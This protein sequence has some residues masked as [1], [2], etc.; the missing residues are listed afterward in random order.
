MK[1][2]QKVTT[3]ILALTVFTGTVN[4]KMPTNIDI[5][6][7]QSVTMTLILESLE[8]HSLAIEAQDFQKD[9]K[10]LLAQKPSTPTTR[11]FAADRTMRSAQSVSSEADE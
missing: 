7:D 4:A 8:H 10:G 5:V 3:A 6:N 1:L 2:S 11:F 9:V